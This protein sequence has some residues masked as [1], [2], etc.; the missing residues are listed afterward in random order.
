M[1]PARIVRVLRDG[2]T[3]IRDLC[4]PTAPLVRERGDWLV[5]DRD[6]LQAIEVVVSPADHRHLICALEHL[7]GQR[8]A[9]GVERVGHGE[10]SGAVRLRDALAKRV[11]VERDGGVA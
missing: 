6:A 3:A 9:G 11:V 2:P 5:V 7:S 1:A 10:W 8:L 4:R